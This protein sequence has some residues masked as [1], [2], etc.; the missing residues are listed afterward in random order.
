MTLIELLI[1]ISVST[2]ILGIALSVY[3]TISGSLRRQNE[4]HR[5]AGV[6]AI[7]ELRH[8]LAACLHASFSNVPAFDVQGPADETV[9][10]VLSSL[11]FCAGSMKTIDDDFA[12]LGVA[13]IRYTVQPGPG[14]SDGGTLVREMV[15]LWGEQALAP[16]TSNVLLNAVT[17]FA[18]T[19]LDGPTWTN[20]WQST[21]A[22]PVPRAARVSLAWK[23][24]ATTEAATILVFIPAGNA[25]KPASAKPK[26]QPPR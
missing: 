13:R 1:A 16:P 24:G 26:E 11:A 20:R 22:H 17:R 15:T 8:D 9:E 25:I 5:D 2:L 7:D 3:V 18:V 12:R 14:G 21:A 6:L 4:R 23:A 10:P 19:A